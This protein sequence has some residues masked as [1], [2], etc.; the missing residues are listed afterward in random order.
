M[1]DITAVILAGGQG[2]RM[3]FVNKGLIQ[4]NHQT[5][6]E[7]IL[8]KLETSL[9]NIIISANNDIE[10][11]RQFSYPVVIDKFSEAQGPLSGILS[12]R[13]HIKTPL[14]LVLP[15]DAPLYP[16]NYPQRM[17]QSFNQSK[18][19][20]VVNDGTR[21]Q[22]LFMLFEACLFPT[23][24][25]YFQQGNRSIKHWLDLNPYQAVDFKHESEAFFNINS[26]EELAVLKK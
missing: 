1:E 16:E 13:S 15:V 10:Q 22:N 25:D 14:V 18:T 5:L 11:Y 8:R 6:I 24:E 12:C 7:T 20:C 23:M 19:T 3:N 4:I 17:L 26:L 2:S 21:I 9:N